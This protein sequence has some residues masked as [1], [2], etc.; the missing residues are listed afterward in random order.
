MQPYTEESVYVN[1]LGEEGEERVHAAYGE[2]K[3]ARLTALKRKY[4]PENILRNNQNIK[5]A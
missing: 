1:C 2:E 3:Y 5:P 4:D